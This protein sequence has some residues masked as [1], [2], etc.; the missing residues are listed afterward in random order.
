[1]TGI[2]ATSP[3]LAQ[4]QSLLALSSTLAKNSVGGT[5]GTPGFSQVLQTLATAA[6]GATGA[7]GASAVSGPTGADVVADARKYLGVPYVF[8]GTTAA[9]GMDCS[10]LV[11]TVFKD[12]GKTDVARGVHGQMVQGEPVASLAD[13]QP[14]DL[15]VFKGGGHIAIYAGDDTVIHA[16]YP[17]RTVSEQKLWTDDS[18]IETI[19]RLVPSGAPSGAGTGAAD[20]ATTS[21][22]SAAFL[23]GMSI[24]G[25]GG[26]FGSS[27]GGLGG[28]GA[29]L[30]LGSGSALGSST[31]PGFDPTLL[32][33][34]I[35]TQSALAAQSTT[36][37]D[38]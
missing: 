21:A 8:G 9:G 30:G 20:A 37:T 19:R 11:Q 7:L 1:M 28:L 23:L 33:Q 38:A 22:T 34:L 14:G 18:G 25:L 15:I 36:E 13:A 26:G 29:G 32:A 3:A 17:G 2:S 24:G 6:T 27:L 16:P 10:G 35:T 4:L 31:T 12:L 5:T